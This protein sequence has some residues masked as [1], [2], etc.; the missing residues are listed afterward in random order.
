MG[1]LKTGKLPHRLWSL[2]R[3]DRLETGLANELQFHLQKETEKNLK[4]GMAPEEARYAALRSFGGVDQVK[5]QCREVRRMKFIETVC[6]DIRFAVRT[7]SK[8]LGSTAVV[9]LSLALGIGANSTM[10]SVIN[11]VL[12]RPLDF[13]EPDRLAVIYEVKQEQRQRRR[14]PMLSS[15][16]EWRQSA[17]TVERMELAVAD[18]ETY[19][20]SGSGEPERVRGQFVTPGLF[21]LLGVRPSLGRDFVAEDLTREGS[22]GIIISN[23]LWERRFARSPNVLGEKLNTGRRAGTVIGVMPPGFWVFP[24]TKAADV[25]IALSPTDNPLTPSTR[26]FTVFARLKPIISLT[27]SQAE[28]DILAQRLAQDHPETNKGWGLRIEPLSEAYSRGWDEVLYLLLG[29]VGF[30]LLIACVNAAHLLLAR[31]A[32]RRKEFAMRLALGASRRRLIQQLLTESILMALIAGVLGVVLS[33]WG[34]RLFVFLAPEWFPRTEEIRIDRTV[35]YFG[36]GVSLLTGLLFGLIPAWR[37]SK[38]DLNDAIKGAEG[39][40]EQRASTAKRGLFVVAEVALALVLL[41]GAGLMFRSFLALQDIDPGF[42]PHNV[43]SMQIQLLGPKYRKILDGDMKRVTPEADAFIQETLERI[44]ALP[45]VTSVGISSGVFPHP[46]KIVGQA[47]P[48]TDKKLMAG[49]AEVNPDYFKTLQI[50]LLKGRLLNEQD[51]EQSPWVVVINQAMVDRYF[52]KEDPIGKPIHVSYDAAGVSVSES[53]PR[54][55]VGI[56]GNVRHRGPWNDPEPTMYSSWRQHMWEY[57]GGDANIHLIKDWMVRTAAD[58]TALATPVKAVVAQVDKDQAVFNLMTMEQ[59]L[60]E[61]L[62]SQRFNLRLYGTF[63]AMALTLAVLGVYGVMSYFVS[64]RTRDF[65]IRMA[66]GAGRGDILGLVLRQALYLSLAGVGIGVLSSLGLTR[67]IQSQLTSQLFG[68]T[69]T[70]PITIVVVSLI[71]A[72]VSLV[73]SYLPARRAAKVN[74]VVALRYE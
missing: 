43:L 22:T 28:M 31:A 68:V 20:L 64:Q 21:R 19:T 60:S 46:I 54:L 37:A 52:G 74:P 25:W 73:A 3:R 39:S 11:A 45:G 24:F 34:I 15:Y 1:F 7:L 72:L 8:N 51:R 42:N 67:L 2:F 69:T 36:L 71:L 12:L 14:D 30:V 4:A 27:Q 40:G 66:L 26:W 23:G 62:S 10:F 63:G 18:L 48:P 38:A 58:P 13:E 9:V 61:W 32:K 33:Y 53:G 17:S 65:G 44:A 5:E 6:Q 50:P 57:P 35:M 56:V 49:L 16:L 47:D 70:D 41:M 55:V 29:A 59:R